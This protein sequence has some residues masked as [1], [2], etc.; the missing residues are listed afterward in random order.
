MQKS[1]TIDKAALELE[2]LDVNSLT[3]LQGW[4]E[5]QKHIVKVNPFVKIED[6][7][8]Y[9][10]AKRARTALVTARTAIEKQDKI[11]GSKIKD[12][13][14]KTIEL[15]REL[16][17]ITLPHEEKQQAEVKKYEEQKEAE[18]LAKEVADRERIAA[19]QKELDTLYETWK[20]KIKELTF[21]DL[22]S[23]SFTGA[24]V[25]AEAASF[26]EFEE[27]FI[28]V[29]RRLKLQLQ[30]KTES[31]T[32]IETLRAQKEE[33]NALRKA[34]EEKEAEAEKAR[35]IEAEA[36]RVAREELELER[37]RIAKM[38]ADRLAKIEA[39]RLAEEA[40]AKAEA[41]AKRAAAEAKKAEELRVK[42]LARIEAEKAAKEEA[43]RLA[44]IEAEKKAEA[45]RPDVE[46]LSAAIEK[47]GSC[48]EAP[49][50]AYEE[51]NLFY[52]R[53]VSSIER[54]KGLLNKELS[55]IN[56]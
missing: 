46:K 36:L 18:R 31:L 40:K 38:E 33:L 11:I 13:R 20:A 12:L 17:A 54:L 29:K 45:L 43:E 2:A 35:Q 9:E 51:S 26:Q 19:I 39:D 21:S 1:L 52:A 37:N 42:E 56:Q 28:E 22:K 3:E 8:T 32:M 4:R 24:L 23:F 48:I 44:K 49:S 30:D 15:S 55:N 6:T 53:M 14:S 5:T 16:I 50:L 7:K 47:I 27:D 25:E 10:E 34:Q 41:E